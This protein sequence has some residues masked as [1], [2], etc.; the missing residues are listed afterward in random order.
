MKFRS[1]INGLRALAVIGVVLFHFSPTT[2]PGGFAGVDVFF[3]ISGFLMASIIFRKIDSEEF[4]LIQFYADRAVRIIPALAVLCCFLLIFGWLYL[5]PVD[6]KVL[7]RQ[8]ASSLGFISNV[9]FWRESGYFDEISNSKWLLHTWSLSV[10]WQFYLI[11]PIVVTFLSRVMTKNII[12]LVIS[13]LTIASFF[14]SLLNSYSNPSQSYFLLPSRIWEMLLGAMVYLYPIKINNSRCKQVM[15]WLGIFL[16]LISYLYVSK[17]DPWPGHLALLPALGTSF[18]LLVN[19]QTNSIANTK[20]LKYIGLWSYSLYLWHWPVVVLGYHYEVSHWIWVGIPLSMILGC[21]SYYSIESRNVLRLSSINI[22]SL[23]LFKPLWMVILVSFSA[24][25]VYVNDG[26][27]KLAPAQY[28]SLVKTASYSPYRHK[29]HVSEYIN[30][31]DACEYFGANVDW[32]VLGDSHATEIAYALAEKLQVNDVGIKHFSFS[33]CKPSYGKDDDFSYCS[34]W[35]NDV[36]DYVIN[37][38]GISNV[39][40]NHYFTHW[41]VGSSGIVTEETSI[42]LEVIDKLIYQ[43]AEKKENVIIFYPIPELEKDIFK[44]FDYNLTSSSYMNNIFS[45]DLVDYL[46]RN[47]A[48]IEHFDNSLYPQ[49]VRFVNP[50][51]AY[52]DENKCY[53][54]KDGKALYFDLHH[55]SVAGAEKLVSLIDDI[56]HLVTDE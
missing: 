31:E 49:N 1:D 23:L 16:I 32:A 41:L 50:R 42:I 26:L 4:S 6:F 12:R 47:S 36:V 54:V 14:Y 20:F 27:I 21:I 51:E 37:D 18:V 19:Y 45:V 11:F 55:P 29:C 56:P 25:F 44:L 3:V 5:S 48:I 24:L 33:N 40:V 22:K 53:A 15:Q 52:C 30:P 7:S 46:T 9:V 13:V 38:E 8:V 10:E 28:Q 34:R 43:M 35:Y 39:V 17:D 2:V